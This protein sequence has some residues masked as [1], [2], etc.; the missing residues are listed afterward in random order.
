MFDVYF[1]GSVST[2]TNK[3]WFIVDSCYY[4]VF[5]LFF[6]VKIKLGTCKISLEITRKTWFIVS[7]LLLCWRDWVVWIEVA[8]LFFGVNY[9]VPIILVE[10]VLG[11]YYSSPG[12]F[13]SWENKRRNTAYWGWSMNYRAFRLMN[14]WS[15]WFIMDTFNMTFHGGIGEIFAVNS[16]WNRKHHNS[17]SWY[18]SLFLS[19]YST[20][21]IPPLSF[22][23][24]F[25]HFILR[26]ISLNNLFFRI[27]FKNYKAVLL[28]FH[29][30]F[31]RVKV[32]FLVKFLAL[33]ESLWISFGW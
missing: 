10:D 18:F 26:D 15:G 24:I 13:F 25:F 5:I 27:F 22:L 16:L 19:F 29:I 6:L 2:L 8:I 12:Y 31:L 9:K 7:E 11:V 20:F 4:L 14:D 23:H 21:L 3:G 33:N 1:H 30:N 28:R 17:R 32:C